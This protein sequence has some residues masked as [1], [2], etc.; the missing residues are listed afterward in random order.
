MAVSFHQQPVSR[1]AAAARGKKCNQNVLGFPL[2][3]TQHLPMAISPKKWTL[4]SLTLGTLAL[5]GCG[6]GGS[7][8]TQAPAAP[9]ATPA[10]S[11][12][13]P[14]SFTDVTAQLDPGGSLYLYVSTEQWL[15][16]LSG[17]LDSLHD[18]ILSGSAGSDIADPQQA[19]KYM[20]L[21][22]DVV[23]KSGLE[24]ISGLGASSFNLSPGLYR[25]K[26]FIHHYPDKG[27]GLIWSV[28]GQAPHPL[29]ELDLLPLDTA[30]ASYGDFD[31]AK[32]INFLRQEA[33]QS[34]IPEVVQNETQLETQF[35][36]MSGMQ[37]DDV[38]NSLNGSI[39]MVIT[40][41][42]TS[43]ISV[44]LGAQPETI[45]TPRIALLLA[46]K[47]D[48]I[49]KQVDKTLTGNPAVIKVEEPGLSMRT[50]PIPAIPFLNL[51]P[52]VAQWNGYLVIASDDQLIRDIIAVK[53]GA[54]GAKSTPE[55]AT[56]SAGLPTEGNSFGYVTKRYADVA[57]QIQTAIYQNQPNMTPMQAVLMQR[58]YASPYLSAG[59]AYGVGAELPNGC[60]YIGQRILG[61][62]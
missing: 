55:F 7:S 5:G 31:L 9:T 23:E 18:I 57:R 51:R 6:Q 20:D 11:P 17:V 60:L 49:F 3:N 35:S 13:T 38:L 22:K 48:V 27:T 26:L 33:S 24:E 39:G 47:S 2:R 4:I 36:G 19:A 50:M 34:G 59:P 28:G 42:S 54:P 16:K 62:Q 43:T 52:T 45:P 61:G 56:I 12:A 46:V 10:P 53:N 58:L 8:T 30:A 15:S 41:D 14:N 44:P 40:L 37:L 1:A 32:F 21:A 29:T 25:N